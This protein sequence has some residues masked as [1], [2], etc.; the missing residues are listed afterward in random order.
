MKKLLLLIVLLPVMA[1]SQLTKE[2]SDWLSK[3]NGELIKMSGG[4]APKDVTDGLHNSLIPIERYCD[5]NFFSEWQRY[6]NNCN[7]LVPDT[8]GQT[9]TV[10]CELVPVKMNGKIVSYNTVPIDTVWNKCECDKYK[11]G[12]YGS[13]TT[14]DDLNVAS[15]VGINYANSGWISEYIHKEPEP[16]KNT[17]SIKRDKICMIKKRKASFEDFFERWCIEKKL[18]EFN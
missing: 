10:K 1:W 16:A 7:E 13:L 12:Y 3:S 15:S 2:E 4:H 6:L 5:V 17:F 18:I 9:G 8:I 14:I 11:H